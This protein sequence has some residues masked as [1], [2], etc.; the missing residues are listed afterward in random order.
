MVVYKVVRISQRRI[1]IA[2][3][4]LKSLGFHLSHSLR[5]PPR[6][7][8]YLLRCSTETKDDKVT[9]FIAPH[10]FRRSVVSVSG[11]HMDDMLPRTC[12]HQHHKV[13]SPKI[14]EVFLVYVVLF[15]VVGGSTRRTLIRW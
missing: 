5:I 12:S 1:Y 10:N 13:W 4:N 3:H 14:Y 2:L 9:R 8:E 15:F 6:R 7:Q 11:S